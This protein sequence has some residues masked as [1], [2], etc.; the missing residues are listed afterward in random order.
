MRKRPMCSTTHFKII[1][2]SNMVVSYTMIFLCSWAVTVVG[3]NNNAPDLLLIQN[4]MAGLGRLIKEQNSAGVDSL[5]G[6]VQDNI[7]LDVQGQT[8]ISDPAGYTAPSKWGAYF[9]FLLKVAQKHPFAEKIPLTQ[10]EALILL[11]KGL[12]SIEKFQRTSEGVETLF[13]LFGWVSIRNGELKNAIYEGRKMVPSLDNGQFS[14][15]LRAIDGFGF[16]ADTF[17]SIQGVNFDQEIFQLIK[18]NQKLAHTI[19]TRQ[20]Y[21]L[22]IDI[23]SGHLFAEMIILEDKKYEGFGKPGHASLWTEWEIP[24]RDLYLRGLITK[25]AWL[26]FSSPTFEYETDYGFIDVPQ[27]YIQSLHELW[28]LLYNHKIIL[29]SKIAP[30]YLNYA[31]VVTEYM[32][33][34]NLAGAPTTE[35]SFLGTYRHSGIPLSSIGRGG[36]TL[37]HIDCPNQSTLYGTALLALIN[38]GLFPWV[39]YYLKQPGVISAYGP[40]SSFCR[41]GGASKIITADSAFVAAT[42]IMGGIS[43]EIL[44]HYK[45]RYGLKE[46]DLIDMY[47]IQAEKILQ[48]INQKS[49]RSVP[50]SMIPLPPVNEDFAFIPVNIGKMPQ[51]SLQLSKG[52]RKGE[53]HGE[54]VYISQEIQQ[55]LNIPI[56]KFQRWI[57]HDGLIASDYSFAKDSYAYLGGSIEH[58]FSIVNAQ[59]ISFWV[60]A[61]LDEIWQFE[62]KSARIP[63]ADRITVNTSEHVTQKRKNFYVFKDNTQWVQLYYP[64]KTNINAKTKLLTSFYAST[65]D[66]LSPTL[67]G[68]FYLR[69]VVIHTHDPRECF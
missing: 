43:D 6:L 40:V 12:K 33:K 22:M 11:N 20:H 49:F 27:G 23:S 55:S 32:A 37:G 34:Y 57:L 28:G 60:P 50:A 58:P 67:K 13:G 30:L 45:K 38:P 63:L 21:E 25:E 64:I 59:Y 5:T 4:A 61:D 51:S 1:K 62:L 54:N 7:H 69:D 8:I 10:K 2:T 52:L 36:Q 35:Y 24:M 47:D 66:T 48:R 29:K 9:P 19:L 44:E 42:A 16:Q 31:Y 53:W 17:S 18:R 41:R 65:N 15:A 39:N 14:E 3:A 46:R 56:E 26:K 68:K